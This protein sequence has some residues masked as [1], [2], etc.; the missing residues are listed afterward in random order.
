MEGLLY[1]EDG[2]VYKGH[3]FGFK[4]TAVGELVFNTSM[5]G[6]QK[7][8]TDPSYKGQVITMTYPLIG[9]YGISKIDN[10]SGGIHAFGLVIKDLCRQPSNS[11]SIESLDEWLVEHKTPGIWGVDTRKITKKIR[12]EG[13]VK[14]V[15]SNQGISIEEAKHLCETNSLRGDWMKSVSTTERITLGQGGQYKVA[16]LD[17]GVKLSILKALMKR[18]CQLEMFPYGTPAAEI[19]EYQPDGIFLTNGPGD[20]EEAAEAVQE[21]A[22]LLRDAGVPVFGICMGHQILALAAG[23][24]TYKLKYG[25]RGGNHGVYDKD[26]K[27]SYITS[28]NHGYAVKMESIMLNGLEVTH[29]NLNDGTVEGMEHRD[30]PVFSVQFHPE[31]SPGPNDSAYLFDKFVTLMKGGKEHA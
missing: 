20:P 11:N 12:T 21:T 25:H 2:S 29:L 3:G 15:I 5:T 17:F 26:T 16:V 13:T 10:E 14:C 7:I 19:L 30:L 9:N 28:Q 18:G 24:K 31:A 22:I 23:G 1:L 4:G 27:R 8:L 6:Y